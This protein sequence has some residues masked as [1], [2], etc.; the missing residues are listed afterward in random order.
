MSLEDKRYWVNVFY[1]M[2]LAGVMFTG[3]PALVII[4]RMLEQWRNGFVVFLVCVLIGGF[5]GAWFAFP[6][7]SA[8]IL[9]CYWKHQSDLKKFRESQLK[10]QQE[11]HSRKNLNH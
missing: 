4:G 3:L 8:G 7:A 10:L 6:A 11:L 9:L 5:K 1:N 2:L